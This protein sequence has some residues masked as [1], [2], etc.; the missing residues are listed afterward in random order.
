VSVSNGFE[1]IITQSP[2]NSLVVETFENIHEY[3]ITEKIGNTLKIKRDEGVGFTGRADVKIY[4]SCENLTS[5]SS[6]GGGK[7]NLSNGW[8]GEK[9]KVTASGGGRIFGEVYLNELLLSMS[10]G[11]RSELSGKVNYLSISSSGGSSHKHF[12]LETLECKASMSGGASA[13]LHVIERLDVSGSGGT[14]VRYR[15]EPE[16]S[17]KLSGGASVHKV[18]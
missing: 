15:G 7:V 9:L 12:N 14:T 1:L 16:I 3:I 17:T 13:E 5:I 11:S 10:G 8:S 18:N 4:L 6:S 2:V